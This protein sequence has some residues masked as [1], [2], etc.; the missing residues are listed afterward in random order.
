MRQRTAC[1]PRPPRPRR[2]TAPQRTVA[3]VWG[4]EIPMRRQG[5]LESC[6]RISGRHAAEVNA[7]EV[8]GAS[9]GG[10]DVNHSIRRSWSRMRPPSL[11]G[12]SFRSSPD[13]G[14]LAAKTGGCCCWAWSQDWSGWSDEPPTRRGGRHAVERL[15]SDARRAWPDD[16]CRETRRA[17]QPTHRRG[18]GQDPRSVGPLPSH[19]RADQRSAA[20]R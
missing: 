17:L 3:S 12:A 10:N 4:V 8:T 18:L 16:G 7:R 14:P 2:T 13:G 1:L 11:D 5:K 19:V 6:R 9:P 15:R 20:R